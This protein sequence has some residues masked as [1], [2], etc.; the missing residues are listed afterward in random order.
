M[1]A[2]TKVYDEVTGH[3]IRHITADWPA[4]GGAFVIETAEG[5][6]IR[7]HTDS[8]EKASAYW[9]NCIK[10]N[11][12]NRRIEKFSTTKSL[13]H[14]YGWMLE[15]RLEVEGCDALDFVFMPAFEKITYP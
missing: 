1:K 2:E 5:M 14:N 13:T 6:A 3:T 8:T 10:A 4:L 15:Y 7:I 11:I 12:F 9:A